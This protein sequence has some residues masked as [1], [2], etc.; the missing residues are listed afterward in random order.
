MNRNGRGELGALV[1]FVAAL[2]GIFAFVSGVQS[3]PQ[4]LRGIAERAPETSVSPSGLAGQPNAKSRRPIVT[5]GPNFG[6]K[7]MQGLALSTGNA[8]EEQA[9]DLF[10][11]MNAMLV[12]RS[13]SRVIDI[14]IAPPSDPSECTQAKYPLLEWPSVVEGHLYCVKLSGGRSFVGLLVTNSSKSGEYVRDGQ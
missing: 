14:G 1:G 7:T 5:P 11:N 8:V 12:P 10:L 13:G 9:G 3:L 6:I 4:L 2:I